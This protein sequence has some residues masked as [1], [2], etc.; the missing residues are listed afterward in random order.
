[1]DISDPNNR[2]V[3][4]Q[5]NG[6]WTAT[7]GQNARISGQKQKYFVVSKNELM[8]EILVAEEYVCIVHV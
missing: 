8:N 4:G 2:K 7:V 1:V 6:L 5:H 3:I